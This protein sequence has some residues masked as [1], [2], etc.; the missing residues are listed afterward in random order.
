[1]P[2]LGG[3]WDQWWHLSGAFCCFAIGTCHILRRGAVSILARMLV[4]S[5]LYAAKLR[6]IAAPGH[7]AGTA[8]AA[9]DVAPAAGTASSRARRRRDH[10][11]TGTALGR[12]PSH[13]V[14][15]LDP[16]GTALPSRCSSRAR[17]PSSCPLSSSSPLS[18][19][20]EASLPCCCSVE[21]PWPGRSALPCTS[22]GHWQTHHIGEP[23]HFRAD[24]G[25][26]VNP[27]L[28][29]SV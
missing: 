8:T 11:R 24:W 1:M 5:V 7:T 6:L 19:C 16:A 25:Q 23:S 18:V 17:Q 29:S 13:P 2:G 12:A 20:V 14:R 22:L 4:P 26:P 28:R 9:A 15:S 10:R 3:L 27:L 21:S